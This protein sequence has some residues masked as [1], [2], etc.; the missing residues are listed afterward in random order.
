MSAVRGCTKLLWVLLLPL[1]LA[2]CAGE[3]RGRPDAESSAPLVVTVNPLKREQTVRHFGVS[4]AWWAQEIGTWQTPERDEVL[5]YLFSRKSGIGL[6]II[7]YNL[8]GG[9]AEGQASGIGDPWR[10]A[11]CPLLPDGSLDWSRDEAAMNIIDGAVG[12]G[13][14]VILFCNSPPA[15]MTITGAPTGNGLKCN[16]KPDQYEA[17]ASYLARASLELSKRWPLAALSPI[18][19]PQWGWDPGKGQEGCHYSHAEAAALLDATARSLSRIDLSLPLSSPESCGWNLAR[20]S[21][22]VNAISLSAEDSTWSAAIHNYALHSYGS[23]RPDRSA[24]SRVLAERL[25]GKE[26]WITEWTELRP[27]RDAGMGSALALANTIHED[28]VYGNVSSWQYWIAL[29]KYN[30]ADGL[31]Y[32]DPESR[33]IEP[34]KKLWAFGN[35]S[36][37]VRPGARRIECADAENDGVRMSAFRNSD[38]SYAFV[39]INNSKNPSPPLKLKL[40]RG[41]LPPHTRVW[42]TSEQRN[43]ELAP[44]HS[45]G[46]RLAAKSITTIIFY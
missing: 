16:L 34:T 10:S 6:E 5:D 25:P 32:V 11:E 20:N 44:W 2:S 46:Q 36:R 39:C 23:A 29:S 14:E 1:F 30:Y 37:F 18:N 33:E 27:G 19:E 38:G 40:A 3:I 7:R 24:L 45:K 4:A 15:S 21:E 26:T 41:H 43:L 9:K 22:Y 8:G 35:W 13:A 12:R 28:L 31:I 17:F 42:E